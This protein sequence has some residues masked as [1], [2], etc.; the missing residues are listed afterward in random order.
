MVIDQKIRF[1]NMSIEKDSYLKGLRLMN[2]DGETII[3]SSNSVYEDNWLKEQIIED[4][5]QIVG[6]KANT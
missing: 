2:L 5:Q 6:V 4:D 1:I 3:E